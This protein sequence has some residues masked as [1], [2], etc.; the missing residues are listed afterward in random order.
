[1]PNRFVQAPNHG[2][3]FRPG[4]PTIVVIHSLEAPAVD[5]MA[6]SLA[7]GWIQ[8]SQVSPHAITDPSETVDL[9]DDVTVGWHCGNGNQVSQG[10]EH[11]GYA[12][13]TREQWL[14]PKAFAALRLGAKRV[15]ARCK[16]Y[17][18]PIRWLS[19]Q[20]IRNGEKGLC[21]HAD[22]A[23]ALGGSTHTD[24]GR[25]FPYD[26]F[27]KMVQQWTDGTIGNPG[28]PPTDQPG[29]GT[30]GAQPKEWDELASKDEIKQAIE[31]VLQV[32]LSDSSPYTSNIADKVCDRLTTPGRWEW[33]DK[34]WYGQQTENLRQNIVDRVVGTLRDQG[35]VVQPPKS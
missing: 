20:Q 34:F 14:A 1:M 30:G 31:E 21:S 25:G 6:Y 9:L 35:F 8:T 3:S 29:G 16:R 2:G 13:W 19:I 33:F 26:L 5:G 15:A 22:I 32:Y 17:N 10:D 18:I 12:A 11:T 7:T 28:N 4:Q 27:I 23:V 24:P